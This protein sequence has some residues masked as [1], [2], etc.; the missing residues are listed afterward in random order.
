MILLD[1]LSMVKE[2]KNISDLHLTLNQVPI[3]RIDG[4]LKPWFGPRISHEHLDEF[5]KL[6]LNHDQMKRLEEKRN[7]DL[8]CHFPG[9]GRFRVSAYYQ[10]KNLAFALRS[11]P[12][13]IHSLEELKVP[14][15]IKDLILEERG[16]ILLTGP[17]G[18]GKTTTLAAIINHINQE[19]FCHIVTLED[20]IEYYHQ[21]KKSM[22]HQREIGTDTKDFARAL[23]VIL[24][25]DPDVIL[26]GEMRDLESISLV[27]EIAKTGHLIFSTL[28]TKDAPGSIQRIL[29]LFPSRQQGQVK[30]QL[31]ASLKA[32]LAQKLVSRKGGGRV[33]AF[34]ILLGNAGV[35]NLIREGQIYQLQ[36]MMKMGQGEGMQTMEEDLARLTQEGIIQRDE[37]LSQ[38]QE[39]CLQNKSQGELL[40]SSMKI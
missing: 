28:H 31:A 21:D 25:Q 13:K 24:R 8:A 23:K 18:S 20:P 10:K 19:R 5:K 3:L 11:I 17:T 34:E 7:L 29:S 22:I 38:V 35:K 30:S 36:S 14:E 15:I 40:L 12:T 4:D 2:S 33:A 9:I 16:L 32:V 6:L 27:L 1:V 39:R 37:D 26:V